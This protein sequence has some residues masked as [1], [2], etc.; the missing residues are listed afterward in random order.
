MDKQEMRQMAKTVPSE[1]HFS[2]DS[3]GSKKT[4]QI[5]VVYPELTIGQLIGQIEKNIAHY[6]TINYVYVV[7]KKKELVGV[8]SIKEVFTAPKTARAKDI[9]KKELVVVHPYTDQERV[10]ILAIRHNIKAIPVVDK[11]RKLMGVVDSDTIL[12]ILHSEH[13]ED[14][15]HF[16]GIHKFNDPHH[17][18][19]KAPAMVHFQ[20]RMPWLML[21]L[22]GGLVAAGVVGSFET[23]LQAQ[24]VLAAFIP[25]VVYIA[26][27]VGTQTQTI[28]IRWLALEEKLDFRRYVFREVKIALLMALLLGIVIAAIGS[29]VWGTLIGGILGTSV[30]LGSLVA[31]AVAIF[32]PWLFFRLNYDPAIASGPFATIIRDILSLLLYFT[33][34]SSALQLW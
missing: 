34:A 1:K 8:F 31:A 25:T 27:A 3:A 7:N 9:M 19:M 12:N 13:L 21:G 17:D 18:I 5:P 26:D 14:I 10:A 11:E 15:L 28:F 23:A 6:D 4:T 29:W 32:L 22:L 20:K 2:P 24:I 33:I 16:A 30:F